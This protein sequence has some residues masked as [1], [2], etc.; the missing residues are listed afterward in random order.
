MKRRIYW[1]TPLNTAKKFDQQLHDDNDA[2]AKEAVANWIK[3]RFEVEV[4]ENTK[5]EVDL[6]LRK[7]G[8]VIGYAEVEVRHWGYRYCPHH[9]IHVAKRKEKLLNSNLMTLFFAVTGDL[10][11]AYWCQ[12]DTVLRSPLV[13]VKNKYVSEQEY[14]YDVPVVDFSY[15]TLRR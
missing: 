14:F 1:I 7:N 11:S 8:V 10:S 13:E 6:I 12:S 15:A 4:E 2:P 3:A 9:T 5:Y